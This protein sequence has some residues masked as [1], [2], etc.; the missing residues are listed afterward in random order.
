MVGE[1]GRV[2]TCGWVWVKKIQGRLA[3]FAQTDAL[4]GVLNRRALEIEADREMARCEQGESSVMLFAIDL[5]HFKR[6][7]DT[8]GHRGGDLALREVVHTMKR[9]LRLGG[10]VAGVGGVEVVVLL[11]DLSVEDALYVR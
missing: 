10:V 9:E 8:F 3:R 4:T 7:N 11:S 5:D 6:V 1:G 2:M